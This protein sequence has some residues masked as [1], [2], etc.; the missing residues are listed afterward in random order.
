MKRL[1]QI[2]VQKLLDVHQLLSHRIVNFHST[3]QGRYMKCMGKFSEEEAVDVASSPLAH[4]FALWP[5]LCA[6]QPS[7]FRWM[8]SKGTKCQEVTHLRFG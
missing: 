3:S 1:T 5:F 4:S 6:F 8:T 7:R 2:Q